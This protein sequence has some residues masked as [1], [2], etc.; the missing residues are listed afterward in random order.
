MS[1]SWLFIHKTR[2]FL[3]VGPTVDAW[4]HSSLATVLANDFRIA[5]IDPLDPM[6]KRMVYKGK[7]HKNG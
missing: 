2:K 1:F 5:E 4:Y 3:A 6:L 7:S